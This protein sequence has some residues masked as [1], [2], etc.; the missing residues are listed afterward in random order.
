MTVMIALDK[1]LPLVLPY[2]PG[3]PDNVAT[4]NLRLAAIEF[5]ERTRCWRHITTITL[6]RD[7]QAVAAPPYAAIHEIEKAVFNNETTLEPLQYSDVDDTQLGAPN[8]APPKYITQSEYDTIRILPFQEGTLEVSMFLK[9]VFGS[10]IEIGDEGEVVDAY[11]VIPEFI[12][13][14]HAE[15]IAAG[16]L[17]RLLAQPDKP[18]TNIQVSMM[19]GQRF[20]DLADAKFSVN[21]TGQHRARRRTKYHDF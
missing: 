21:L 5:C 20:N 10:E 6:R 18:W 9:P 17:A 7:G 4:Y 1:M 11:D 2:A 14:A 16:A 13:K 8:E 15:Q 19:W 12:Y 3:V